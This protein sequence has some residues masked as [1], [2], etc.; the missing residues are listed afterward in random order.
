MLRFTLAQMRLSLPRLIAGGL[1]VAI[2]SAF[3]AATLL[4]G[5]VMTQTARRSVTASLADADLVVADL[6]SP[7]QLAAVQGT[8]GVA[9]ASGRLVVSGQLEG[10]GASSFVSVGN[11]M[12]D[13]RLEPQKLTAGTWP[14]SGQIALPDDVARRARA[15][16]GQRVE[17][18]LTVPGRQRES[19]QRVPLTVSGLTEDPGGAFGA[20]GGRAVADTGQVLEWARLG[21]P[22]TPPSYELALAL[23]DPGAEVATVQSRVQAALDRLGPGAGPLPE[24]DTVPVVRTLAQQAGGQVEEL[25]GDRRTLLAFVLAFAAISLLVAA[26]V[27]ANTFQVL[28]AQ[29]RQTLALLRCVGAVRAQLRR[30]VLIEALLVGV[31]A[32]VTGVLAGS[33]LAQLTLQV[34]RRT[35]FGTQLPPGIRPGVAAVVLPVVVG[36]LVTV[37][38]SLAPARAATRVAPLVALRPDAGPRLRERDSRQRLVLA[39]LL[40][41]AGAVALAVPALLAGHGDFGVAAIAVGVL[42]GALSFVGILLAAVFW[43]PRAVALLGRLAS[44]SGAASARLAAANSVRNPRRTAATSGALLI[45]VTLVSL[46]TTGAATARTSLAAELDARYPVDLQVGFEPS[47]GR[48]ARIDGAQ[49]AA[50]RKVDGVRRVLPVKGALLELKLPGNQGQLQANVSGI[51][52]TDARDMVRGKAIRDALAAGKLVVSAPFDT[53]GNAPA[54]LRVRTGKGAWT[55]VDVAY[56]LRN[57]RQFAL[58]PADLLARIAPSARPTQAWVSLDPDADAGDV[59]TAVADAVGRATRSGD[60]LPVEGGAVQRQMYERAI[61]AVLAVV[62]GLV[63]VSV[64]IA[65]VGVANTL[66]LSV[67]ERRRESA[68]LRA[69]GLT[70]RQLRATLAVEGMVIAAAGAVVGVLLGIGYG[71]AGTRTVLGGQV[72]VHLSVPVPQLLLVVGLAVLA[73]LLAS[74]L[75]SRG[76]AKASPVAALATT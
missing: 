74:V 51:S 21:D 33:L 27:I 12:S 26:L 6:L 60:V 30:S 23:V 31:A 46:M 70:R 40:V 64:L 10:P 7:R 22:G 72:P 58:A 20:T 38:A 76:A 25:T 32:S 59:A 68:T 24:A 41:T 54:R 19:R 66:S 71:W 1:A 61:G 63:A 13:P 15:S 4:A 69:V 2:G 36:T 44:S 55:T 9:A 5:D 53:D 73:G 47:R 75:P 14:A 37:I 48:S 57:N 28:V 35:S 56:V 29:R 50:I 3:V 43:V 8:P 45:G 62:L 16:V 17:L 49:L 42:G 52:A 11:R 34:L 65:V 67:L 18:V 39:C